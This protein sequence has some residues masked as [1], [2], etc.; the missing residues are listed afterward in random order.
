M[1]TEILTNCGIWLDKYELSTSMNEVSIE[2]ETQIV[3]VTTFG[4]TNRTY[5]SGY[6]GVNIGGAGFYETTTDEALNATMGLQ[7]ALVTI[8]RTRA[9][10]TFAAAYIG[11][12][13]QGQYTP[14]FSTA[15]AASFNMGGMI[16]AA[17]FGRGIL[18]TNASITATGFGVVNLWRDILA[19]Q[20]AIVSFHVTLVSGTSPTFVL[21]IES[22]DAVGFTTPTIRA[23]FPVVSTASAQT[24]IIPGPITD[25]YWRTKRT[26]GGTSP[27]FTFA[28]ALGIITG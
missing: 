4:D 24:I 9:A 7:N 21:E 11:R 16:S 5:A 6:K 2:G 22:D 20:S 19:T 12:M 27:Q 28:C 18:L 15:E 14:R 17:N 23:T 26:L 25:T 13:I 3:D 10:S 8:T 1:A